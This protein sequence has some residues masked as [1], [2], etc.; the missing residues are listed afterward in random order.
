VFTRFARRTR[1]VDPRSESRARHVGRGG[2]WCPVRQ[3][4]GIRK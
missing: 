1:F 2:G 3:V 4:Y